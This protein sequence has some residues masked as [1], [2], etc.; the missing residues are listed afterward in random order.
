MSDFVMSPACVDGAARQIGRPPF[1][2]SSLRNEDAG[3]MKRTKLAAAVFARGD[4]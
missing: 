1:G 3:A 4:T 2:A